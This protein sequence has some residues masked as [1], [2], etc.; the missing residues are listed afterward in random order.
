MTL[1]MA[2]VIFRYLDLVLGLG[3]YMFN[4]LGRCASSLLLSNTHK[5]LI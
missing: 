3:I 1:G 4:S 2:M 5:E